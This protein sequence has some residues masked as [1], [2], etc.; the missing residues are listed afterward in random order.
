[1]KQVKVGQDRFWEIPAFQYAVQEIFAETNT[2]G[3]QFLLW[4]TKNCYF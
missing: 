3:W 1:M 2:C 4:L